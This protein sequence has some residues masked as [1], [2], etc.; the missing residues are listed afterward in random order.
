[1]TFFPT[2]QFRNEDRARYIEQQKHRQELQR[3]QD[4]AV[5][6]AL[7]E[8]AKPPD[9]LATEKLSKAR[10]KFGT[11]QIGNP[12]AMELMRTVIGDLFDVIEHLLEEQTKQR[13]GG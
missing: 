5:A 7:K 12:Y 13:G 2:A 10:E 6:A 8:T 11:I 1:M 3:Q 9:V 4:E